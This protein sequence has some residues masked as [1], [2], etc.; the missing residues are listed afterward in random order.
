VNVTVRID[1]HNNNNEEEYH[2]WVM[3][4]EFRVYLRLLH[5]S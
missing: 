3:I 4:L 5:E 1:A 2:S